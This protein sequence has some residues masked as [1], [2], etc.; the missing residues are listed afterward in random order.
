[1]SLLFENA[2]EVF[3]PTNAPIFTSSETHVFQ[4]QREHRL[5]IETITSYARHHNRLHHPEHTDWTCIPLHERDGAALTGDYLAYTDH[6]L[7]GE[8]FVYRAQGERQTISADE[9][10]W[11]A[12][13]NR[14]RFGHS[15]YVPPADPDYYT[16]PIHA[17][18]PA[19]NPIDSDTDTALFD[20]LAA[21]IESERTAQ[22]RT[23]RA[24]VADSSPQTIYE[25]D[26]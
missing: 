22:R 26:D 1:M 7:W 13:A 18:E 17:R 12:L 2:I 24:A 21:F 23:N 15:D 25:Q 5:P 3:D 10:A 8:L 19:R 6:D 4:Q 14:V 16:S 9:F 20:G 11:T